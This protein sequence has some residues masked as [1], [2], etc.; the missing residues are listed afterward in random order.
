M[1]V[2]RSQIHVYHHPKKLTKSFSRYIEDVDEIE[3]AS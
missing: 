1:L 3:S 2:P